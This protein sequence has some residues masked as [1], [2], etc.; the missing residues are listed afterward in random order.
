M[1]HTAPDSPEPSPPQPP[2]TLAPAKTNWPLFFGILL[3][4]VVLTMFS[5]LVGAKTGNFAP[6]IAFFGGGISGIICGAM[7]AR[8][9]ERAFATKIVLGI[10]FAFGIGVAC[11]GMSCFGCLASGFNLNFH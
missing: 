9:L 4:P 3:A 7:L 6:V 1:N 2:P 5:V 10:I 8:R 11:I